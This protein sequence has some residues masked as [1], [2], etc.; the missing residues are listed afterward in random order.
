LEPWQQRLIDEA[1]WCFVR[2]CIRTDG[3]AFINR[4]GRYAYLSYDFKNYSADILDLF[5]VTCEAVGLRPRRYARHVRLSRR[6]DVARLVQEV[7]LKS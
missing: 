3:C 6:E 4:T 2:G 7:G 1:P 5:V